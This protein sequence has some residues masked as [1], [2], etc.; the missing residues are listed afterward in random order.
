MLL[1]G[2]VYHL[3]QNVNPCIV[4]MNIETVKIIIKIRQAAADIKQRNI[5]QIIGEDKVFE[6]GKSYLLSITALPIKYLVISQ[7]LAEVILVMIINT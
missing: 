3:R 7:S 1:F 5:S 4:G 2:K 6:N